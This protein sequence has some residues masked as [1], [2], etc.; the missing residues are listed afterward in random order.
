MMRDRENQFTK[1]R[2]KMAEQV[3]QFEIKER[4]R[5][6]E[7]RKQAVEKSEKEKQKLR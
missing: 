4:E 5:D 7:R 1:E 6:A 3:L 2:Q